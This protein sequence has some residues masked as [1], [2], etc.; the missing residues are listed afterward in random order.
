MLFALTMFLLVSCEGN[1]KTNKEGNN[2]EGTNTEEV[3]NNNEETAEV[4]TNN[5]KAETFTSEDGSFKINFPGKPSKDE[6]PVQT[7]LGNLEMVTYMYEEGMSAYMVAYSDYPEAAIKASEPYE[8][9]E[10]AK[11][12]YLG[13]IGL[14]VTKENNKSELDGVPGI[15]FEAEGGGYYTAV[16]DYLLENRLYQIAILRLDRAPNQKE[17]DD[18]IK[19]FEFL[20]K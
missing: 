18:F 20:D 11:G 3:E 2:E 16:Q 17:I 6:S 5:V 7:E 10:G 4:N 19:S 1:K 13:N 8:L 14:T 12:G 15:Y 9:L